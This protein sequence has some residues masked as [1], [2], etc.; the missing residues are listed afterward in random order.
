VCATISMTY[1][2][3]ASRPGISPHGTRTGAVIRYSL[4]RARRTRVRIS[5]YG[6]PSNCSGRTVPISSAARAVAAG[7][8]AG[9]PHEGP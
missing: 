5:P 2:D 8:R 3:S 6:G 1:A 9:N 7:A 4:S